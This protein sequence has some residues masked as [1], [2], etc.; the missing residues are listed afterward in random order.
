M[1]DAVWAWDE[2]RPVYRYQGRAQ[3]APMR[4]TQ[5]QKRRMH[6]YVYISRDTNEWVYLVGKAG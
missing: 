3:R 4:S 6:V 1:D 2:Q 5:V